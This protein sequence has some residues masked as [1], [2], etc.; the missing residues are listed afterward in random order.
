[1]LIC[2]FLFLPN[3]F[4]QSN[5]NDDVIFRAVQDELARAMKDL[6]LKDF[7]K[8]YFIEYV[9]E[10]ED[11]LII[12]SKFGALLKS[13]RERQRILYTQVRVGNYDFDNTTEYSGGFKFP[14]PMTLDD[15]YIALRR[16][17]WFVT[18]F[19]YKQAID[20]LAAKKAA[21]QNGTD[22]DED[23]SL[24]ALSKEESVVSIGQRGKLEIDQ[25][26]WEKQIRAWSAMFRAYP[27]LQE[28]TV[29]FYVRQVNRYM[30]NSEG[31]KILEPSLLITLNIYAEAVTVPDNIRL[32]PSRHLYAKSFDELPS[33]EEIN[34]VIKNLAQDLVKLR[35]APQ[36]DGKYIGPAL[37]T[38][39]ATVQLFLQLLSQNLD[40]G[41]L[42]ERLDRKVLPTFLSVVD[43]PTQT[44]LDNFRLIGD[45][46][47]DDEGVPAKRLT[48]IENGVLKTLLST[49]TP[50][51]EIPRSNGRARSGGGGAVLANI[52]NLFVQSKDGKSFAELKQQLIEACRAQGLKYGILFREI[53][54]TFTPQ[55]ND[56]SVPILAYKV[57]VEDG[58]EELFRGADIFDLTVRELRQILAAGNDAHAF[59]ILLGNGHLGE[60]I[61]VSLVAPSV[62]LD[63][64]DLRKSTASKER[65]FLLTHPF[66]NK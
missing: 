21:T 42:V 60:G 13:S 38:E 10:D 50:T 48:L 64:I 14:F 52:S 9:V 24:P 59:N 58:R 8:P 39:R 4:S 35:N 12:E 22:E 15:D 29:N 34:Q 51:K 20:Q 2:F 65:P 53:D 63:E 47:I 62:L 25:E 46:K 66:F 41:G 37:F 26:K 32:T 18:D 5:Q 17:V 30:V 49:R 33:T 40:S 11:A 31:T 36:F 54:S 27:E 16:A 3:A 43:D 23:E 61:P 56:L 55:E 6:K 7:E 19:S 45:Y 1:L 28:S 57:Y 44:K